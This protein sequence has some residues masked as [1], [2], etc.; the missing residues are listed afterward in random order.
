[1]ASPTPNMMVSNP[2][3]L[4]W[5]ICCSTD[6]TVPQVPDASLAPRM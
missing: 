3:N 1:M 4:P 2:K 5:V 6:C